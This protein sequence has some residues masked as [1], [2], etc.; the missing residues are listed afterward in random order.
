MKSEQE[1][2]LSFLKVALKNSWLKINFQALVNSSKIKFVTT[3]SVTLMISYLLC[4]KCQFI[5][6]CL[7][8]IWCF[9]MCWCLSIWVCTPTSPCDT[10][11]FAV[12]GAVQG[13]GE[14]QHLCNWMWG[15][16]IPKIKQ[17][18]LILLKH[19]SWVVFA[20]WSTGYVAQSQLDERPKADKIK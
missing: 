18:C 10:F 13:Q 4:G 3:L 15:T 11:C 20:S 16:A 17:L 19:Y 9:L 5:P 12:M 6:C 8:L 7:L 1:W 2:R 14:V